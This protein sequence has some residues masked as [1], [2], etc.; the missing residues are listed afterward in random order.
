[1]SEKTIELALPVLTP[2]IADGY[3]GCLDRLEQAFQAHKGI[4]HVHVEREKSPAHL[5]VHYDPNLVPLAAV[6]RMAAQA[7]SEFTHRYRH[8]QIP[9]THMNAADAADNLTQV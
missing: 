6:K 9:F 3:D 5:C 4:V 7:G 1:M 8:E 2:E